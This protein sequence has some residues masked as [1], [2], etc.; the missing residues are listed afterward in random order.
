MIILWTIITIVFWI[1][2]FLALA[3]IISAILKHY[4]GGP[5]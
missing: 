4:F 1:L 5:Q 2:V 3:D